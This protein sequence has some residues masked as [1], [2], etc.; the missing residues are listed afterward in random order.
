VDS[1]A[2][3]LVPSQRR[4]NGGWLVQKELKGPLIRRFEWWGVGCVGWLV[5]GRHDDIVGTCNDWSDD[6]AVAIG[7]STGEVII[8]RIEIGYRSN[9]VL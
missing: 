3:A 7:T 4:L 6:L 9:D 5:G 8:E 2:D 1:N